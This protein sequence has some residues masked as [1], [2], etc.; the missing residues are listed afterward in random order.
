[1]RKV[2]I[3]VVALILLAGAYYGVAVYPTRVFRTGLDRSIATLPNGVTVSYRSAQYSLLSHRATVTGLD[4]RSIGPNAFELTVDALALTRPET[5]LGAQWSRAAAAPAAV[6]QDLALAIADTVAATGIRFNSDAMS[7]T[8]DRAQFGHPRLYPWALL[9]PGVPSLAQ[10]Q[11]T[12]LSRINPQPADIVAAFRAEAAW[13]LGFGYDSYR[14]GALRA[15]IFLPATPTSLATTATYRIRSSSGTGYDRGDIASES[16]AGVSFTGDRLGSVGIDKVTMA[17][18]TMRQPLTRLLAGEPVTPAMLD[19]LAVKRIQYGPMTIQPAAGPSSVL[20]TFTLGSVAFA[21]GVLVSADL[22]L[23]G[24][25]V[26][27]AQL[28]NLQGVAAFDA[29]GLDRMTLGLAASYRWDLAQRRITLRHTTLTVKE[30]GALTLALELDDAVTGPDLA[31]SIRLGRT[32]L[33]Y[34]DA[35]LADRIIKLA[36][37]RNGTDPAAFRQQLIAVATRIGTD[38]NGD[39]ASAAAGRALADFLAA[40]HSLTIALNPPQPVPPAT[41]LFA[42]SMP[43]RRLV[44]LLGLTIAANR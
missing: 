38:P 2:L 1:M 20:G 7:I 13:T 26:T 32:V 29:L 40:P 14:T 35:S 33:R 25:T 11:A 9:R 10:V 41:L 19:G 21:H 42:A 30:L 15:A 5:D 17:G 27:R 4:L 31:R 23:D 43:P 6:P 39:P 3:G 28:P 16:F 37:A 24:L 36:A 12:L 22:A 34:D 44:A 18:I 8:L